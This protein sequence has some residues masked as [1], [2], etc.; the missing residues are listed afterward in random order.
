MYI[1]VSKPK[2]TPEKWEMYRELG[3]TKRT[4]DKYI[5]DGY[6]IVIFGAHTL[7]VH[8]EHENCH[9]GF[10]RYIFDWRNK[11]FEEAVEEYNSR[12]WRICDAFIWG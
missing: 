8:L 4:F 10:E 1:P 12:G 3:K 5:L 2:I 11:S 6:G 7:T 9:I